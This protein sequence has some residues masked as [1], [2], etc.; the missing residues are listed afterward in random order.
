MHP[1]SPLISS[2]AEARRALESGDR[3]LAEKAV[4]EMCEVHQRDFN[5]TEEKDYTPELALLQY[6]CFEVL[7]DL[8]ILRGDPIDISIRFSQFMN[9]FHEDTEHL[10]YWSKE[11]W[12]P[13]QELVFRVVKKTYQFNQKGIIGD[14]KPKGRDAECT[15]ELCRQKRAD[16]TGSH[17]VPHLLIADVFSYDGSR[18]R[19]KV[20]VAVNSLGEGKQD[21]YFGHQVYDDT[22]NELLGHGLSDEE[23]DEGS[24]KTNALTIDHIFCS[25]CEKRFSVLE[26]WYAEILK[27][28]KDY[29]PQ[30]PYLFWMSVVWRMAVGEMGMVLDGSH[31]EKLRRVLD[32]CLA[33]K[34]EDIILENSR[35]GHCAYSL[36]VADDTRDED[37][38]IFG[39][40]EETKPYQALMG[41]YFINFYT[42]LS[43]AKSFIKAHNLPLEDLNDGTEPE[44]TGDLNFIEFW[45]VKRQ[46]LDL[47]WGNGRSI[48]NIGRSR[49]KTLSKMQP[50]PFSGANESGDIPLWFNSENP[51]VI[52]VPRSLRKMEN[53]LKEHQGKEWTIEEASEELGYTPGEMKVMTDYWEMKENQ[54]LKKIENGERIAEA[55][56][57]LAGRV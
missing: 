3:Q 43:A 28:S 4:W 19:D 1:L 56:R 27:G 13:I 47:A 34:R 15:C 51:A 11:D 22:I 18:E 8:H 35:L 55:L 52:N 7:L 33:L 12:K 21:R 57:G 30:I 10:K 36:Y 54:H 17:M 46:I 2:I 44:K 29:P 25:E 32:S 41:R 53:W 39:T 48:W 49:Q 24:K 26:D 5:V 23:L 16:K 9:K 20:A 37:L 31:Q 45:M 50:M 38:G 6:Q 40:Y 14:Y 42:S